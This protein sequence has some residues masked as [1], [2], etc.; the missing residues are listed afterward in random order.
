MSCFGDDTDTN[1][2]DFWKVETVSGKGWRREEN[3]RFKH[4]DTGKY[5]HSTGQHQFGRP[6]AQQREVCTFGRANNLNVWRAMEGMFVKA[7]TK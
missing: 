3:V 5:L 1:S 7:N 4:V 6:I 2:A